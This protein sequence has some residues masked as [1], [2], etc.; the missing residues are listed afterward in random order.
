MNGQTT[1]LTIAVP[2]YNRPKPLCE[3]VARLLPQ[4]EE[5]C[6]LRVYD[7]CSPTPMAGVLADLLR[8][9]PGARVTVSRHRANLGMLGNI[10]R[11][12]EDCPSPWLV[13]CGDDDPPAADFVAKARR[14]IARH[15]QALFISFEFVARKRTSEFTTQGLGGFVRG[16]YVFGDILSISAAAYRMEA[17]LPFLSSV[18]LYAYSLAPHIALVLAALRQKGGQCAFVADRLAGCGDD[19]S[20]ETWSRVWYPN[21]ALLL[22]LIPGAK[23]REAFAQK[24]V[25][26]MPKQPY[27]ADRLIANSLKTGANNSFLFATR[28]RLRSLL[29]SSLWISFKRCF[30]SWAVRN[31]GWGARLMRMFSPERRRLYRFDASDE[32]LVGPV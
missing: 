8:Q 17:L 23:D 11:C 31:P 29:L 7:N 20:L 2:T 28:M 32:N 21:L 10:I 16:D 12:L 13:M 5:D 15:P 3:T 6:E 4:L 30:F 27:L 18:Y 9:H 22:E 14:A 26:Y 1:K 24:L 19:V 25:Y